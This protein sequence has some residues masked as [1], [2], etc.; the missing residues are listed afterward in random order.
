M[1]LKKA[2]VFVIAVFYGWQALAVSG[3]DSQVAS[4]TSNFLLGQ[5]VYPQGKNQGQVVVGLT[6]TPKSPGLFAE[7]PIQGS[8]GFT[9]DSQIGFTVPLIV[10]QNAGKSFVQLGEIEL[11]V[12]DTFYNSAD[13]GF[14][15]A[16]GAQL[17]MP[18]LLGPA[19]S[20]QFAFTPLF[21]GYKEFNQFAI[22]LTAYF[23]VNQGLGLTDPFQFNP[24]FVVSALEVLGPFVPTLEVLLGMSGG[25]LLAQ[26]APQVFVNFSPLV[27]LGIGVVVGLTPKTSD[28]GALMLSFNADF[29]L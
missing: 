13:T 19:G 17:T 15:F 10:A 6:L 1:N 21:I 2:V 20:K 11:L 5:T 18:S 24:T 25:Q 12:M 16:A 3:T 23:T 28:P 27:A 26:V 22:N 8:I 14:A 7:M 4:L 9:A 29:A